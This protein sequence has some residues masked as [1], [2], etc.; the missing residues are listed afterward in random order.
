MSWKGFQKGALRAPQQVKARFNLGDVTKDAIFID[1]ERRFQDLEK[2]TK[3]LHDESTKYAQAI[4]GMLDHQIEFSK[5]T[6]EIYKP[7]SGRASD[8][9]SYVDDV[10]NAEG[11][12]ACEEYVIIVEELKASLQPELELIESRIV[13][14][15]EELMDIVK[16]ARKWIVKRDHKQLDFD[17]ENNKMKKLQE[18]KEKTAKDEK[19]IW[20]TEN[21]LEAAKDDFDIFNNL[22]KDELMRLFA[23]EKEFILPLFQS[24]YYMQLNVFY[25]L[26]EKMQSIDIGYFNLTLNIE[27][28]FEHK[29]GEIQQQAEAIPIVKFKTTGQ[30]RPLK[31]Q[32]RL[33]IENGSAG[34]VGRTSSLSSSG[35]VRRLTQDPYD[36]SEKPPPPYTNGSQSLDIARSSSTGSNWQ[37]A[38]KTKPKAAPP[39]P[40]PK[41]GRLSGVPTVETV[42]ALYD[43][44]AQAEGDLSFSA[45]DTIEVVSRTDNPQEW[46]SGKVGGRQ[47]QF[48]GNYVQL[49]S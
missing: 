46:W 31:Y 13:K 16:N 26:H 49:N 4:N 34:G 8:P 45:G 5:A 41:P 47:G 30:R 10:G 27:E 11:L 36:T 35:S 3:K 29:R 48:P 39:P 19:A 15:A 33:G 18:K 6:E 7:V 32:S 17:K 2:E 23:M 24:F 21:K 9:N 38:A 43:Y 12:R 42:T 22:L 25:T 1:A 20:D 28:A 40:K 14:P 44:E 37:S